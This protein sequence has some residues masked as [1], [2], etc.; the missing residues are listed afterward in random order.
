MA[1]E[2]EIK[3]VA[4]R[5]FFEVMRDRVG[6]NVERALR[7]E[8]PPAQ[9]EALHDPVLASSWYPIG[10]YR[11]LHLAAQ[12]L[13]KSGSELSR[14]IG[15]E[16]VSRDFQGIYKLLVG[17]LSPHWLMSW[18]P[19]MYGRYF[20]GGSLAV[21]EAREGFSRAE[22]RGCAGFDKNLWLDMIGSTE[23]TLE[24]CGATHVRQR[25]VEGGGDG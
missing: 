24:A 14:H 20:R 21:P 18:G 13:T 7:A 5:T 8:L 1:A 23:A 19:R 11:E 2:I 10:L 15:R 4:I 22:W 17:A 3:G 9:R 12:R 25:I 16:G 6:P